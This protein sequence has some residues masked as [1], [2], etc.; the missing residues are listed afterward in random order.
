MS[1]T[2]EYKTY[3]KIL[4]FLDNLLHDHRKP[5]LEKASREIVRD[6]E[7]KK[8]FPQY[9]SDSEE[10]R[11]YKK[12]WIHNTVQQLY[13]VEPKI[14]KNLNPEQKK[15]FVRF[16]DVLINSG[17][18]DEIFNVLEEVLDLNSEDLEQLSKTLLST[19]LSNIVKTIQLVE[20]RYKAIECL[21]LLVLNKEEYKANEPDHIQKIIESH[22]WIFGEEYALVSAEEPSIEAS[23]KGYVDLLRANDEY[24]DQK[25]ISIDHIDKRKQMDIF[26]CGRSKRGRDYISHIVVELKHPKISLGEDQLSQVKKYMRVIRNTDEFNSAN[27]T[28]DFYLVGNKFDSLGYMAGEIRNNNKGQNG[29]YSSCVFSDPQ[30]N[31]N[32]FVKKWSEV[33]NEFEIRYEFLLEKLALERKRLL[34]NELDDLSTANKIVEYSSSLSS[35][36]PEA[37]VK[38]KKQSGKNKK[39]KRK[40][41]NND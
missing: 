41:V 28:W 7:S 31:Y 29:E 27:S 9:K 37:L 8:I 17:Q 23:L 40:K 18:K 30:L 19:R 4:K 3:K 6:F 12:T 33:F 1:K 22:Y 5:F 21:K 34:H 36:K 11:A 2:P 25:T 35:A 13:R 14:F 38:T 32:I 15:I 20:D 10:I 24:D 26:M 39:S 16:L